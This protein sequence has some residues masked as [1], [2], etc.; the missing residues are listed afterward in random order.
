VLVT[1]PRHIIGLDLGQAQDF[2]ALAVLEQS[3]DGKAG[4]RYDCRH[5]QRWPLGTSYVTIVDEVLALLEQPQLLQSV[6]VVDQTGVGRAVV[7]LFREAVRVPLKAVT[8][9]SGRGATRQANGDWHV[10]KLELA[11]VLQR[12]L[13]YRRLRIAPALAEAGTLV[14]ELASFTVKVTAAGN[15]QAEAW[16]EGDHDDL[17]LSLALA[18]WIGQRLNP[19]APVAGGE[20][21]VVSGPDLRTPQLRGTLDPR[22]GYLPARGSIGPARPDFFRPFP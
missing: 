14:K 9:T 20:R 15:E 11:G 4:R 21:A 10:A 17:V 5:L 2:T 18:A 8:I 19:G 1:I 7:D 16:R 6:L 12:L 22:G 3:Y 13:A